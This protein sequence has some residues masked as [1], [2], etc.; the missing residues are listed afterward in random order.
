[1]RVFRHIIGLITELRYNLFI[2]RHLALTLK[3]HFNFLKFL[4]VINVMKSYRMKKMIHFF[5]LTDV[6]VNEKNFASLSFKNLF[7]CEVFVEESIIRIY[8]NNPNSN[9]LNKLCGLESQKCD[10][11]KKLNY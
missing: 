10:I 7:H 3:F 4:Q 6:T 11:L 8:R 5:N 9:R 2:P 1:M